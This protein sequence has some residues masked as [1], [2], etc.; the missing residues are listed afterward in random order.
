VQKIN[1]ATSRLLARGISLEAITTAQ[2]AA[3][4]GVSVGALYRFFPDK[5]AIIDALAV[6]RVEE[7]QAALFGGLPAGSLS[8]ENLPAMLAMMD[9]P[10][11][12]AYVLDAFVEFLESYPDLVTIAY[13]GQHI[14]RGTRER[15]SGADAGVAVLI[16]RHM[17]QVL[18]V[19][20]TPELD[21]RLRI[22]CEVG[23]RLLG[24]AMAQTERP[25]RQNIIAE[26]KRL[27]SAYLFP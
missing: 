8:A 17:V 18:G 22:A 13:G 20:L 15:Q 4:A 26:A 10:A 2:I 27:L 21:L 6:R 7:F 14:S 9:G 3:E 19:A 12:L 23:D 24:L 11:L 16:K 25:A 5:Q 1:E